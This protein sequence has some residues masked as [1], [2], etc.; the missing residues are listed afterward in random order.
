MNI[1]ISGILKES[2]VDGPGI[3]YV[4]FAQG[5]AH[6]CIG[7]HNPSTHDFNGGYIVDA[8]ELIED[9]RESFFIDGVT[10]SGGDP[11]YQTAEFSYIAEKLKK[12]SLHIVCYTGF[13][14]EEI[15]NDEN[16]R[17]LLENIDILIDGPFVLSKKNLKLPFRGSDNQRIIDVKNSLKEGKII[18]IEY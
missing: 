2:V 1:R 8:D 16:K 9:I 15:L 11:F 10:F 6:N 18:T 3:R 14:F 13:E 4:V 17:R 5:C 7:C 12:E